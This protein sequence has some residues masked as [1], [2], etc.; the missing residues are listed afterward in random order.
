MTWIASSRNSHKQGLDSKILLSV[1][2]LFKKQ[3]KYK[4]LYRNV[5]IA[6]NSYIWK[7]NSIRTTF[8]VSFMS[9][10]CLLGVLGPFQSDFNEGF[11]FQRVLVSPFSSLY[12]SLALCYA[13]ECNIFYN[14][15]SAQGA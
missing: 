8:V 5:T 11:F 12:M 3:R 9:C 6:Y 13:T 10:L 1:V 7:R 14:F 15:H 2:V 4:N